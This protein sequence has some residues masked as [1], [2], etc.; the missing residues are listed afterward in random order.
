MASLAAMELD[1]PGTVE[2][3]QP[4]ADPLAPSEGS[5]AENAG[6]RDFQQWMLS[7]AADIVGTP[8]MPAT[9]AEVQQLLAV[10]AEACKAGDE[11]LL[12]ARAETSKRW[13]A[14][15]EAG[16]KVSSLKEGVTVGHLTLLRKYM[17]AC[18]AELKAAKAKATK[19]DALLKCTLASQ[20]AEL[21]DTLEALDQANAKID[22]LE[23]HLKATQEMERES[24]D[25][26][27]IEV[28][29]N[30]SLIQQL[31]VV[32]KERDDI[33]STLQSK[34]Q[35]EAKKRLI[36]A[37]AKPAAFEGKVVGVNSNQASVRDWTGAV[38]RYVECAEFDDDE[39]VQFAASFLRGQALR[40]WNLRATQLAAAGT[41][42]TLEVFFECLEKRFEGANT[43]AEARTLLDRLKQLGKFAS[44]SAYIAEFER[45]C[46]F[47]PS[48]TEGDKVHRFLSGVQNQ[49]VHK[50]LAVDPN[51]HTRYTSFADMRL[52]AENLAATGVLEERNPNGKRPGGGSGGSGSQGKGP[53]RR[54]RVA[55]QTAI[56]TCMYVCAVWM[57]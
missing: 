17:R 33:I 24:R 27:E 49:L 22:R 13:D 35:A 46:T 8:D 11:T 37:M 3:Q 6:K 34:S 19:S 7:F 38:R 53:S 47:I 26:C 50:H 30:A 44:L 9:N 2:D 39:A 10:A 56:H 28:G 23:S 36:S 20:G 15:K 57:M 1:P 18:R 48:M 21:R 32:Q 55:I 52:A 54:G 41:P 25:R 5:A 40:T 42:A 43:E 4:P 16:I 51:T 12:A 14:C 45:L 29:K 31:E